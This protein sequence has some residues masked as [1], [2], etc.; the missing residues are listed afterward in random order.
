MFQSI[1]ACDSL[2]RHPIQH[3]F[4][5]V[6]CKR[7]FLFAV[8]SRQNFLKILLWDVVD[9]MHQINFGLVDLIAHFLKL[10]C[11]RQTQNSD[12]LNQ[13]GALCLSWEKWTFH[14]KFSKN[15]TDSY[16]I[17][18]TNKILLTPNIDLIRVVSAG[19]CQLRCSVISTHDIGC[20]ETVWRHNFGRT[21]VANLNYTLLI[22][23]NVFRL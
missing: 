6:S 18:I 15:T 8:I 22:T 4:N 23:Q 3:L 10:L 16:K 9:F 11:C 20:I 5:Q 13:H 21:K 7:Y 17:Q 19:Q 2:A 14:Q 1:F 12:L